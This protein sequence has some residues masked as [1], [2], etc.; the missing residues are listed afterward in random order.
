ME[1]G[2]HN[3]YH[4]PYCRLL[5]QYDIGVHHAVLE[6]AKTKR[7]KEREKGGE[8]GEGGRGREIFVVIG[9]LTRV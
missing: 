1:Q 9:G 7:G 2:L 6:C 4:D 8:E 5:V 3:W